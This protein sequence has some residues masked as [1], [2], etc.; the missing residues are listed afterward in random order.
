MFSATRTSFDVASALSQGRRDTQEDAIV[1]DFAIGGGFG[2]VVLA[3]GMGGH[4]AGD[5][6]STIVVTEVYKELKLQC[7]ALQDAPGD[8]PAI[9]RNATQT[10]NARLRDHAQRHP[11]TQGMG[12]T[13]IALVQLGTS[14]FWTSVGDS[15]LYLLRDGDL[16]RLNE[17]HSLAPQIDFLVR[18]GMLTEAA[19]RDHPDRSVLTSALNGG[20]IRQL[21]CPERPL[22]LR[23]GDL[24]VAASDGLPYLS[25]PRMRDI[26]ADDTATDSAY[27]AH[28]L[29]KAIKTLNHPDQDNVC[30][31]IIRAVDGQGAALQPGRG[32]AKIEE[33]TLADA[34]NAAAKV[35]EEWHQADRAERPIF[36]RLFDLGSGLLR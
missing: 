13:M 22:M 12:S 3:D 16:R 6:A 15:V 24:I 33:A 20:P 27:L 19:G 29:L 11:S 26:L 9:L 35:S 2:L 30:F 25:H 14:L 4:E 28:K 10:A 36:G 17:D 1:T 23:S 8:A 21:D 18:Q 7:R 34:T 5:V 31:A 32:A